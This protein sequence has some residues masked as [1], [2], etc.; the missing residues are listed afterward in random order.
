M[1]YES[2]STSWT[3]TNV[4]DTRPVKKRI[5]LVVLATDHTSECDFTRL[6]DPAEIGVYVNRIDYQNPGT[7]ENLVATGPRLTE[8]AAQILPGEELDVIAYSCTAAS[9]VLGNT[10]VGKYLNAGK[11]NTPFVSPSSAAFD[12]FKALNV[13]RISV[14]TPYSTSISN[15]LLRYFSANGPEIASANCLGIDDDREIARLSEETIIEAACATM[16]PSA[17][18][19]FVSCTGLRAAVCIE[20]I[21]ARI[22]KPVV[23]SNQAMIWRCFQHLNS[24]KTA[25]G[26]GRLFQHRTPNWMMAQ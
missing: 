25:T 24:S 23:T 18:A 2:L 7:R 21:E 5:G 8:A 16:D 11:P 17:E 26:F 22:G 12:A 10:A 6:C 4:L 19:L 14:L 20:R 3:G 13:Q 9:I 15:E 1:V